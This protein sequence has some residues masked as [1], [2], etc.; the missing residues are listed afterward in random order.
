MIYYNAP[1]VTTLLVVVRWLPRPLPRFVPGW[2][3]RATPDLLRLP[4]PLQ[5]IWMRGRSPLIVQ[6][7]ALPFIA[8]DLIWIPGYGY[9]WTPLP[10]YWRYVTDCPAVTGRPAFDFR[11]DVLLLLRLRLICWLHFVDLDI[12]VTLIYLRWDYT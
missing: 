9:G 8:F 4:A 11:M 7:H 2:T 1:V 5:L 3:V 6:P 10:G 12:P